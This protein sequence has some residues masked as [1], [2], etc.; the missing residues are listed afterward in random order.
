MQLSRKI[1]QDNHSE[2]D[3]GSWENSGEDARYIYQ[4]PARTKEQR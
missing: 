4:R 1:I 2:D 3:P